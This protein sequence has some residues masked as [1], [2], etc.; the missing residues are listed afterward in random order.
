MY[1]IDFQEKL[2]ASLGSHKTVTEF[3]QKEIKF[4]N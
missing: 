1:N 2:Q 4:Q 3:V